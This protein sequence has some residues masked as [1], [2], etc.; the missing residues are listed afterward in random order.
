LAEEDFKASRLLAPAKNNALARY[1]EV[2]VLE[3][4]QAEAK[5]GIERIVATLMQVATVLEESQK[6]AEAQRYLDE[7]ERIVPDS[8]T[9]ANAQTALAKAKAKFEQE[10]QRSAVAKREQAEAEASRR[11]E[12]AEA[13]AS[14]R[15]EQAEA[16]AKR[17]AEQERREKIEAL[18]ADA[19]KDLKARRLTSPPGTNA[20]ERYQSVLALDPDNEVAQE[21]LL[22]IVERYLEFR[23][24]AV[25]QRNFEKA[26]EYLEK[27]GAVLPDSELI[28]DAMVELTAAR[29]EYEAEQA[30]LAAQEAQRLEEESARA[31]AEAEQLAKAQAESE[32]LEA[33]QARAQTPPSAAT[34]TPPQKRPEP[35]VRDLKTAVLPVAHRSVY[36]WSFSRGKSK[37]NKEVISR[38]VGK[39][40]GI[41]KITHAFG[42]GTLK[43][44]ILSSAG[45]VWVTKSGSR[46]E[47]NLDVI[48]ERAAQLPVDVIVMVWLEP[49]RYV[50]Q[51]PA[52]YYLIDVPN[53]RVFHQRGM[54]GSEGHMGSVMQILAGQLVVA[55]QETY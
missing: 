30:R 5:A 34:P 17:R 20:F 18:L 8:K 32:R 9:V 54:A 3:P 55:R 36:G 12:Q 45:K 29:A 43:D 37:W 40:Y 47:P 13:E 35:I 38:H 41:L 1:Q 44:S 11:A 22:K 48:Y 42:N 10:L 2:L 21:G 19:G 16:E 27:A 28:S 15:A 25:R 24:R 50:G 14:R 6:Y 49:E 33:A 23:D 4:D 53:R 51:W 7:A 26:E 39:T 31:E 52:E 46:K